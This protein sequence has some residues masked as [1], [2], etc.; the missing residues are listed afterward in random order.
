MS[1]Y[2]FEVK[3]V[4]TIVVF[5]PKADGSRPDR[6]IY[7]YERK[8]KAIQTFLVSKMPE[9]V[10]RLTKTSYTKWETKPGA[11]VMLFSSKQEVPSAI[12]A[13]STKYRGRMQFGFVDDDDTDLAALYNVTSRPSLFVV[14]F[15][16]YQ[17]LARRRAAL[18]T[19]VA[20][21]VASFLALVVHL[22]KDALLLFLSTSVFR[23]SG[24][25][26]QEY[27]RTLHDCF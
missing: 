10:A 19:P 21:P 14:R 23:H 6:I 25:Q 2:N 8:A 27:V 18:C 13:L 20:T 5:V 16:R 7:E 26:P 12:K 24:I 9:Y 4:P 1:E 22:C 3:G 11:K 15:Q 17:R